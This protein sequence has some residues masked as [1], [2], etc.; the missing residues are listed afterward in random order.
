VVHENYSQNI[1]PTKDILN[2]KKSKNDNRLR[3]LEILLIITGFVFVGVQNPDEGTNRFPI[4]IFGISVLIFLIMA[5]GSFSVLAIWKEKDKWII[6]I[7]ITVTQVSFSFMFILYF[8]INKILVPLCPSDYF[9]GVVSLFSFIFFIL[10]GFLLTYVFTDDL[11]SS[12]VIIPFLLSMIFCTAFLII[13]LFGN[14]KL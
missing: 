1:E 2:E 14:I 11:K 9:Y 13:I 5:I 12:S 7:I 8:I 10:L 4:F 6:N 3:L